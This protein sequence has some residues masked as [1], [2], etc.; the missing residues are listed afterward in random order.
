M[1]SVRT[2][3]VVGSLISAGAGQLAAQAGRG[4]SYEVAWMWV[5]KSS[6]D[7]ENID[8]TQG[9][10][11][12]VEGQVIATASKTSVGLGI[13]HTRVFQFGDASASQTQVFLD[14]RQVFAQAGRLGALYLSARGGLGTFSC[15]FCDSDI[16][17]P[18][19]TT[20]GGGAGLLIALSE[21]VT[22]DVGAQYHPLNHW[23]AKNA[24]FTYKNRPYGV[25]RAGLAFSPKRKS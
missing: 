8:K 11:F 25:L 15:G 10:R 7:G 17:G 9:K 13:S 1:V 2:A 24:E 5:G 19:T 6:I 22:L 21:S 23:N 16:D 18:A 3:V 4:I 14:I 12:G 20:A